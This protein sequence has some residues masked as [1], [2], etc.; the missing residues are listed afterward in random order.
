[1]EY[2]G[3]GFSGWQVQPGE[4]TVQS[5]L[6][7]ALGEL[8]G[9]KIRT[10]AAGRT[11]AGVHALGQAA[12]FRTECRHRP[13]VFERGL[14][15][16]LP[17]DVSVVSA[18]EE[19]PDFH[20][21]GD[22]RGKTYSYVIRDGAPRSALG[23]G[24]EWRMGRALDLGVMREAAARLLGEH[25]FSSFRSSSCEA[26]SP[27]REIGR[28]EVFRDAAGRAVLE[29]RGRSFLKQMV[30]AMVGTLV[31]AGLGKMTPSEMTGVLEAR[32]RSA[33]GPTA[34]AEGLYLV[35]VQYHSPERSA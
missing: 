28:I 23:R 12:G 5:E 27:V 26:K 16:L 35:E 4:R 7:R 9:E 33:A 6:E 1:M 29:F 20:A 30:R 31:E 19:G 21:R 2:D 8:A 17:P 11:D 10:V 3:S 15:A 13:E 14:N 34:P 18:V 25:D 24:R 32:D 22:A